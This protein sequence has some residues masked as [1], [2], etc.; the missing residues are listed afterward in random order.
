MTGEAVNL[1]KALRVACLTSVPMPSLCKICS[2]AMGF[3]YLGC[4][5]PERPDAGNICLLIESVIMAFRTS[6]HRPLSSSRA[7]ATY[8]SSLHLQHLT[9]DGMGVSVQ[10]ALSVSF[11][12]S[13]RR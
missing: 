12:V 6:H 2:V 11:S 10:G 8:D 7:E 5:S 13:L 1:S 3:A 9:Q 4:Y